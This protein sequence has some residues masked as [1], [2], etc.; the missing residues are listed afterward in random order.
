M[1]QLHKLI[2]QTECKT[3]GKISTEEV[4]RAEEKLN[5]K[6][7][8]EYKSFLL[9]YGAMACGSNEIIGLGVEGYLNVVSV[10]LDERGLNPELLDRF[11]VIQNIGV[12]GILIIMDEKGNVYEFANKSYKK[13]YTSFIDFLQ[14]E[15][16][17]TV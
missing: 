11:I 1:E 12:E 9:N 10:T 14:N 8:D 4:M 7:S 13:I 15:I 5:F 2:S 16:C 6:F 17:T 3:I